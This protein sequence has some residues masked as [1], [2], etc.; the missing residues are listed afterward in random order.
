MEGN[1]GGIGA[2]LKNDSDAVII[3]SVMSGNPAERA[4]L[5]KGDVIVSIQNAESSQIIKIQNISHAVSVLH[6]KV[7][8]VVFIHIAR[9]VENLTLTVTREKIKL[10]TVSFQKLNSGVGYVQVTGHNEETADDFEEALRSFSKTEKETPRVI[11]D[12]RD[13]PGGTLYSSL[14]MLFYFSDN[15]KDIVTTLRERRK[16]D[17][18]TIESLTGT[19][20][21][22]KTREKKKPGAFKDY[23]VII[24][25]NNRSASAAE[26]FSGTMQDWGNAHGKFTVLGSRSYGKG[27][28]QTV[29]KL[30]NGVGLKLTTFEF[31]VGNGKQK[32][33]DIG[34]IPTKEVKDTRKIPEDT[35]TEEDAQFIAALETVQSMSVKEQ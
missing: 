35:L 19:F 1:F 9:G 33:Q 11:V 25:V 7:G 20:E 31:L 34:V 10:S 13:N 32:I 30:S 5:K 29:Y 12:M 21:Y 26:M 15:P 17:E 24:L 8:S 2:L 18:K 22:P 23:K 28:G 16:E 6:G 14:E 3:E 4:G 27:V